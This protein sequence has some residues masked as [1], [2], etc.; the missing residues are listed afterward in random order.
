MC[1]ASDWRQ[2]H[3]SGMS[4]EVSVATWYAPAA[5]A[6]MYADIFGVVRNDQRFA[7]PSAS[8]ASPSTGM[9]DTTTHCAGAST[10]N[11]NSAL[12]SGWSNVANARWASNGSKSVY[13]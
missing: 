12:M 1:S 11:V 6:V 2:S 9:F 13:V 10:S 3:R 8:A 4:V 7:P 5:T